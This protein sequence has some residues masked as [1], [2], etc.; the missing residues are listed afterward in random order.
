MEETVLRQ[1]NLPLLFL[2]L[3]VTSIGGVRR[4]M[5]RSSRRSLD[6][7]RFVSGNRWPTLSRVVVV[8][9]AVVVF[10][11]LQLG[12]W[13]MVG[14][15]VPL[16]R[17]HRMKLTASRSG[18][19]REDPW[20]TCHK[21]SVSSRATTRFIGSKSIFVCNGALLDLGMTVVH[22]LFWRCHDGEGGRGWMT[23]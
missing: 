1:N 10:G 18:N 7:T 14:A 13:M 12:T 11:V 4:Q 5:A 8:L 16:L 21:V 23:F 9:A 15:D 20:S 6:L 17:M 19:H 22:L 3:G 2:H